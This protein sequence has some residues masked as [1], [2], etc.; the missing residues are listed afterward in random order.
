[1]P[2]RT[3]ISEAKLFPP[4]VLLGIVLIFYGWAL[5][6][7]FTSEDFLLIRYLSENPPWHNLA[8]QLS[9]PWLGISIVKFYRPVSTLLYGLEIAAFGGRP[10]GYN[11][12]HVLVHALNAFL[13]WKVAG[14][15]GGL[16]MAWVTAVLF[17]LYPLHPNAVIFSA[18]FATI[19]G[20]TFLL[21]SVLAYQR[22]RE[23][24]S[25]GAWGASLGLFILALGS[26]E[27]TAV[28]PLLLAAYDHLVSV[29]VRDR[30]HVAL[31]PG[32]LPFFG[33]LGLYLLFR[34]SLFGVV[35]GGYDEYSRQLLAPQLRHMAGDLATSIVQLHVPIYGQA[36]DVWI[37]VLGCVLIVGGPLVLWLLRRPFDGGALRLWLFAWVWTLLAQAPFAF[38]PSVPGNGRYWYLAAAGVALSVGAL[39]VTARRNLGLVAARLFGIF[40]ALLL[41]GYVGDYVDAG[42]TART[43]QGEL[44]R[45]LRVDRRAPLFLTRYPY[46]LENEAQTPIA[47][48]YHYGLRDSVQP[49]FTRARVSVYPLP[50]LAGVELLPV[51]LGAPGSRI[52]EWDGTA[53]KIHPFVPPAGPGLAELQVVQPQ[54]GAVVDPTKE[55]AEVRV[56]PGAHAR[57]RL[58]VVSRINGTVIDLDPGALQGGVLR[59]NFPAEFLTTAD[60]L[61]G[62]GEHY[63]WIEARDA[64]GQVSGFSRMRSFRLAG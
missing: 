15:L 61:Y 16:R 44:L 35:L 54:E 10:F 57:F 48:I 31:A 45:L 9:S 56:P 30:R 39:A 52:Y 38:R 55:I 19:F 20:A 21:A 53:R 58:I 12:V 17:A 18:S 8:A 11:L 27:E 6:R 32:Y 33:V 2:P 50:P 40:W 7:P 60:H 34:R 63:W 25:L 36:P 49:P 59:A 46:F 5:N 24:G 14:K 3:A 42:R 28:L 23:G 62:R 41:T 51:A 26:Y 13:V 4:L 22:F 1:M 43:I 29:R 47:Q 37:V 64:A